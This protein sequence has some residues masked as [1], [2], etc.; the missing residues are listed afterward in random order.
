MDEGCKAKWAKVGR[1]LRRHFLTGILVV[2]PLAATILILK[3]LFEAID[4]ILEPAVEAI[5]G[6][7]I[8]GIGF[9]VIIIL[10]LLAGIIASNV[11]GRKVIQRSEDFLKEV[12]MVREIYG[13]FKQ[14]LESVM[15]PH[16][17]GFKEVVLVEF[18]R[19]GM[20]TIGFITN[21]VKDVAGHNL[22][23]VY[24]PTTPNPTSG[25]LEIIPEEDIVRL[26]MPIDDAIKMVVSGGMVSPEVIDKTRNEV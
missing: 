2:V 1:Y 14:V 24:I 9:G 7:P 13:V 6:H 25:Y 4:G 26:D 23:N 22:V 15:L 16:K 17:G 21:R 12:P 11:F 20:K 19:P 5:F 3:W 18:P 8:P 10:L